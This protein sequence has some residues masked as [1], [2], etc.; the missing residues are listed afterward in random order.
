MSLNKGIELMVVEYF[1]GMSLHKPQYL[2]PLRTS[3][4]IS[5]IIV[6][7]KLDYYFISFCYF[8]SIFEQVPSK[9]PILVF[10]ASFLLKVERLPINFL[11]RSYICN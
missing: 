6:L 7:N 5:Y 9:N 1:N 8:F 2:P 4:L 3:N 11:S 10:R